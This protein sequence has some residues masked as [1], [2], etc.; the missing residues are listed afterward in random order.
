MLMTEHDLL[1]CCIPS[2]MSLTLAPSLLCQAIVCYAPIQLVKGTCR[3]VV[4]LC[5]VPELK[6]T[7]LQK[8]SKC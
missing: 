2:A 3:T 5:M 8:N 7:L 6:A 1:A 4:Y